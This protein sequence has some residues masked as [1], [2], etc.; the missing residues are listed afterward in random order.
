MALQVSE[1]VVECHC[2]EANN[3]LAN[4][5]SGSRECNNSAHFRP[6]I[7]VVPPARLTAGDAP[8]L[9]RESATDEIDSSELSQS[10]CVKA[11]DVLEARDVRPMLAQDGATIWIDFAEGGDAHSG[12]LEAERHA[13]NP[14][15]EIKH[16]H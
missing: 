11:A 7:S 4:N 2:E 13:A 10:I 9:T 12:A 14:G 1:H 16:I 15:E 6:E 8:R 5:P 3:V